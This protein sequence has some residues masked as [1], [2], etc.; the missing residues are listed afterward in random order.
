MRLFIIR[1]LSLRD[2]ILLQL[3]HMETMMLNF[4]HN[5]TGMFVPAPSC[6]K[7]FLMSVHRKT[8]ISHKKIAALKIWKSHR[9]HSSKSSFKSVYRHYFCFHNPLVLSIR[10]SRGLCENRLENFPKECPLMQ[11]LDLTLRKQYL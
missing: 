8:N 3:P 10:L 2:A 7:G 5:L 1:K 9:P 6:C 4:Q 11:S